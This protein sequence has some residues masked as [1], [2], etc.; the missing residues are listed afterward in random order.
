MVS[1]VGIGSLTENFR[2]C[3]KILT[4]LG[5]QNRQ[6]L[7]IEMMQMGVCTGVRMAI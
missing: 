7:M 5:D 6:H 4:A 3:Q 2:A 1:E